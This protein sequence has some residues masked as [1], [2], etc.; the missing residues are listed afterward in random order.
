VRNLLPLPTAAGARSPLAPDAPGSVGPFDYGPS[1]DAKTEEL[2]AAH[3]VLA[4]FYVDRLTDALDRMPAERAVLGL[5]CELTL[6]ADLGRDVGDIGCGTGRLEPY[7]AARGL[8]P[9]GIDLSPEMIRVARRDHPAFGFD[10]ADLREL[11]FEN[12]SLAGVICWYSLMYLAPSERPAAFSE[13]ARV[14]RPG[15]YLVTA[16]KAGDG[17]VRRGGRSVNLGVEFDV[18]W[19]SPDE[20]ERRVVDAG[21]ATV[22]WG[23]RP[24]EGQEGSPQGYLLARRT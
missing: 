2:R 6:A 14:V 13:L 12:A 1:V 9:R 5:F 16:F 7:L 19:L 10:V 11:P 22:F 8:S 20:V 24:A 15:G 3:D 23:G 4:E 18:Y 17:Q 21:F